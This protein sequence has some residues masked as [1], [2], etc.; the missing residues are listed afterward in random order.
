MRSR[1]WWVIFLEKKIPKMLVFTKKG[2]GNFCIFCKLDFKAKER[3][4]IIQIGFDFSGL[5][6]PIVK[7]EFSTIIYPELR[8][9]CYCIYSK[10]KTTISTV[11]TCRTN[12]LYFNT[13][14]RIL[15]LYRYHVL[16]L[17][18]YEHDAGIT[19][20]QIETTK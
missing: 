17:N 7:C 1:D 11:V 9:N 13:S 2:M 3:F 15:Y 19:T 8:H 12:I 16:S 14:F 20:T 18:D 10:I 6:I 5:I 4:A